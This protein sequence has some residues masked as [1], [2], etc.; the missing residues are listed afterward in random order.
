VAARPA[1]RPAAYVP[2]PST[3]AEAV[4][5][6]AR[7]TAVDPAVPAVASALGMARTMMSVTPVSAASA[8]P[9]YPQG[10]AR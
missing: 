7:G 3:P 5:R 1:P 9:L 8:D 10:T 6:I 2:P 4:A